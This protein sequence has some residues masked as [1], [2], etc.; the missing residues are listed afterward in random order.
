MLGLTELERTMPENLFKVTMPPPMDDCYTSNGYLKKKCQYD[1]NLADLSKVWLQLSFFL[2]VVLTS[3]LRTRL[4]L[5]AGALLGVGEPL[6]CT[7]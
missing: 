2:L 5:G 6:I 3:V 4:D 1:K 7:N